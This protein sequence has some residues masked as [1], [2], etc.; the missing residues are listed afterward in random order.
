MRLAK[1]VLICDF[2]LGH[3]GIKVG[4]DFFD[5]VVCR[6][7]IMVINAIARGTAHR[8]VNYSIGHIFCVGAP[9]KMRRGNA[10][11]TPIPAKVAA[12]MSRRWLRTLCR[13]YD[14]NVRRH[15]PPVKANLA[16][17]IFISAEWEDQAIIPEIGNRN[18]KYPGLDGSPR[19]AAP[20]RVAMLTFTV[21]MGLTK[22]LRVVGIRSSL[23]RTGLVALYTR[24]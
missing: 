9:L 19:G 2:V 23:N 18:V 13:L 15:V 11:Q 10:S 7:K 6:P 22:A 1:A 16:V 12:L 5:H 14:G 24:S 17:T 21:V 4:Y 3:S 20:K 8:P